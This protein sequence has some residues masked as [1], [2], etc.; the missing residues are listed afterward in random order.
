MTYLETYKTACTVAAQKI[1]CRRHDAYFSR[2]SYSSLGIVP[3][4]PTCGK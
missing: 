2:P 1:F 4:Y 3:W